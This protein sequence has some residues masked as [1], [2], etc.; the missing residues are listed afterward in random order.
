MGLPELLAELTTPLSLNSRIYLQMIVAG[1]CRGGRGILWTG[2]KYV[3]RNLRTPL[4]TRVIHIR[5]GY[6]ICSKFNLLCKQEFSGKEILPCNVL[7]S[8]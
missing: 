6:A 2:H 1:Y 8:F 5:I 4:Q 7:S 3:L